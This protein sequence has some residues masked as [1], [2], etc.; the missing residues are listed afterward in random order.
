VGFVQANMSIIDSKLV[1]IEISTFAGEQ[2]SGLRLNYQGQ[3]YDL[4]QAFASHKP[5]LV[6]ARLRQLITTNHPP[7]N[8]SIV[9][10]YLVVREERYYSLWSLDLAQ[11]PSSRSTRSDDDLKLQQASIWL[12]QELWLQWQDLLGEQQLQSCAE[13]LLTAN[14]QLKSRADFD[15]LLNLDPLAMEKLA[16]WAEVDFIAFDQQ[17]Y[18]L[19]QQKVGR[20]F[21][22][23]LTIDIM[24][25]MP[26][27]Q[28]S[29][30][31]KILDVKA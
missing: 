21:G 29:T 3:R 8:T 15:R 14:A 4:V 9:D 10:R 12:F 23:R 13:N 6:Q 19:T 16:N 17:L 28:R 26:E 25:S 5:E 22:T 11:N 30:L 31:I 7:I 24:D 2:K 27:M 18:H 20:D 1:E